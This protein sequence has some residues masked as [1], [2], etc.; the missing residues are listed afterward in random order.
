MSCRSEKWS[1][2]STAMT[3][4]PRVKDGRSL[5]TLSPMRL[6]IGSL[7]ARSK[8]EIPHFYVSRNVEMDAVFGAA[9]HRNNGRGPERRVTVT[10]YLIR[11]IAEALGDFP[12]LNALWNDDRLEVV[13]SKNIAIAVAVPGGLVAPALLECQALSLEQIADGLK[14]LSAR[15]QT[16]TLKRAE[17]MDC[18]FTV[19]NLG[20]YGADSFAAIITSPQVAVLAVG[21]ALPSA[22]VR[23]G[24]LV[25]RRMMTATVSADHRVV[26][27][28]YAARFLSRLD[29]LLQAPEGSAPSRYPE[30]VHSVEAQ[31]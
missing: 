28:A 26:D 6:T 5:V 22:V 2:T 31:D 13:A 30:I 20:M 3:E 25:V 16:G 24:Q 21:V 9:K 1:D 14:D 7:M 11:A 18:T 12:H 27:G 4:G 29:E 15:A 8:R 19:S 17:Y 10:A 23:D